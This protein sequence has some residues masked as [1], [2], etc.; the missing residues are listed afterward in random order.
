MA[1][2]EYWKGIV[3]KLNTAADVNWAAHV[4]ASDEENLAAARRCVPNADIIQAVIGAYGD[5]DWLTQSYCDEILFQ[6]E[7]VSVERVYSRMI[8]KS[9]EVR[10]GIERFFTL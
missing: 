10:Q 9:D 3:A 4:L 1:D 2:C 7:R 5:K 6:F 8:V